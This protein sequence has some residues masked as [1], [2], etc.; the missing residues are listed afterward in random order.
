MAQQL[1][2]AVDRVM[3][4]SGIFD[5]LLAALAIKQASGDLVE[6]IFLLRAYRRNAHRAPH[7]GSLQR[8]ARWPSAGPDL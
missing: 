5:T 8:S 4:E 6:A 2:L 1:G 3:T 7:L